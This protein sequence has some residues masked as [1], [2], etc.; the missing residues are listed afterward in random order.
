[1]IRASV[2]VVSK[3][4]CI[5]YPA[6]CDVARVNICSCR[7]TTRPQ[8]IAAYIGAGGPGLEPQAHRAQKLGKYHGLTPKRH[9]HTRFVGIWAKTPRTRTDGL[10]IRITKLS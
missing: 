6:L 4:Y 9:W 2:D 5:A 8:G 10:I 1:M 7:S 3:T